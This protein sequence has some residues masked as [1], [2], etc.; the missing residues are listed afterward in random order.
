[1]AS[2]RRLQPLL[3]GR[4]NRL[5][6]RFD[7]AKSSGIIVPLEYALAAFTNGTYHTLNLPL[8]Y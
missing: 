8:P 2:V 4:V 3:E 7:E 5:L 1:M 6:E